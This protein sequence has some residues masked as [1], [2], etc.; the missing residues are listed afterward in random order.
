MN[1]IKQ[2]NNSGTVF[3]SINKTDFQEMD[4][5][6]PSKEVVLKFQKEVKPLDDKIIQNTLQIKTLENLRDTLLSKLISGEVRV[7]K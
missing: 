6:I 7:K 5:T 1:Q 4:I 2:F 3:G